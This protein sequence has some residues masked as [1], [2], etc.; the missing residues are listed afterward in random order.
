MRLLISIL[1]LLLASQMNAQNLKDIVV[2]ESGKE[3]DGLIGSL[4]QKLDLASPVPVVSYEVDGKKGDPHKA[5]TF[6]VVPDKDFT[7]GYKA[8]VTFTNRSADTVALSN[9]VPLGIENK[10]VYITGKG[11]NHLSRTH[12]FRPD[13]IPVNVIVPDNAWELGYSGT[14]IDGDLSI[15][16]L[17]RRDPESLKNAQ[18][19]RFET[20]VGP[21]GSVS[22]VL[23]AELY[24]GGWQNGLRRIFQERHLYDVEEFDNSLYE[25]EDLKWIRNAYVIHLIM[26]WDKNFYDSQKGG[27]TVNEFLARGRRLY[28]GDDALGLW[29]TWPTLGTDQRNQFDLFRELPGGLPKIKQL[30][31]EF[32]KDGTVF[33][34]CYNPWD[35]SSREEGHM[36]GIADL[37]KETD[38]DGVVLDTKGSSSKEY[39]DAADSIKE[40]VIMYSEGMAVPKDM[41]GIVSGRVH[42]ALYYPPFLNLNKFIKPEFALFRVGELFKEPIKREFALA[43]FNG[44]GTELNIFAPGQ[45]SWVNEQYK[46]LGRTSR[47]LREN[48]PNFSSSAYTPLIT[49][50][51]DG[52]YVN[53]WPLDEKTIYTVF[54]LIPEGFK[55]VLFE[56]DVEEDF[57]FVDLWHHKEVDPVLKDDR[58]YIEV[59]TDAFNKSYLGSNNE[60]EVD[61]IAKLP[62]LLDTDL[63][64][65]VLRVSAS[66]GSVIKIWAGEPSYDKKAVELEVGQHTIRLLDYLGRYEGKVVIQLFENDILQDENVVNIKPGTPRLASVVE[67]TEIKKKV[68]GMVRIPEGQF[69]FKGTHGDGF[70]PYPMYREGQVFEMDSYLM[71]K[72]P[73][74]NAEFKKFIDATDYRPADEDNFLRHWTGGNIP[75]GQKDFPVVYVSYEDAK[76]FAKWAKKRLPTELEWQYAAQAGDGREWPWSNKTDDIYREQESI[77][78]TL[79][80]FKI[81]GIDEKYCNLGNGEMDPIGK[82][83]K[84]ANPYGLEDLVGSVWQMTNDL[85][86]SGSYDYILMK[87]GSY[88]NPA[89]SWWYVQGGPR[90]LHYREHLLRVSQSFERNATVGFRCVKDL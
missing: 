14:N 69:T 73:V 45:P 80:V 28:G 89:S 37:I 16:A 43:F 67:K 19:K 51:H 23:Y 85:Y 90:E 26:S 63:E 12:L 82:Y 20:L 1:G 75:E 27:Y 56:V 84:G 33:F 48:S 9:V 77:T 39:Q 38:A 70:I 25:R 53:E 50:L 3:V 57:H 79:T 40:G 78:A 59:E 52:I 5:I 11:D 66:T 86:K 83:P 32:R 55:E 81:K 87:G 44:H 36:S 7:K 62:K 34:L 64:N 6:N 54:S 29:P 17:T 61:C 71:D 10:T 31:N 72:H 88:Y 15:C 21:G 4:N 65:D 49:T 22:Y 24:K 76:A 8:V 60:S 35:E 47:I 41:Q 30:A 42:N 58:Y 2:S 46:Y 74:T 18:A 13:R 68:K